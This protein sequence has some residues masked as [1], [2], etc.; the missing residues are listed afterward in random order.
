MCPGSPLH[1]T[2]LIAGARRREA[3]V[4]PMTRQYVVEGRV[5]G[6]GFRDFVRRI[7]RQ[8]GVRG[9]VRNREDGRV[10][11]VATAPAEA[12]ERFEADL[13]TGSPLSRIESVDT[14]DLDETPFT[15]FEIR[16]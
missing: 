16:R 3:F 9:W 13:R 2:P 4:P 7:A 12:L 8:H 10:E 11:A 5:Q 15:E 14:S 1:E 6:I